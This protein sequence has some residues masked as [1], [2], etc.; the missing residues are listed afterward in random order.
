[1]NQESLEVKRTG[2]SLPRDVFE[3]LEEKRGIVSR[4]AYIREVLKAW[5][6]E[7]GD[8]SEIKSGGSRN[9]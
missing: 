7:E 8:I 1:M 9:G 4:S 6:N 2:I 5:W 3:K